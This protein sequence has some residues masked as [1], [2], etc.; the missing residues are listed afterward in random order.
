[1]TG[2]LLII[3]LLI[4]GG[5]LATLGDRLG[6]LIGK[7]RLSIFKLRP[8]RTAVFITVLTGS[9]ISAISLGFMLLVS[10]QLR[11]GLFELDDIQNK[12]QESRLALVPLKEE[13]NLL[14]KRITKGERE[15]KQLQR[16]IFSLRRGNVVIS[17]GQSLAIKTFKLDD[18]SNL[19]QEIDGLLNQANIYSYLRARPG[20]KPNKRILYVRKDNIDLI[21][22]TLRS[23]GE[24]VVNIRS[25]NNVLKGDYY[26]IALADILP[27]KNIVKDGEVLAEI[28]IDLANNT[29]DKIVNSKIQILL[30]EAFNEVKRRGSI[31]SELQMYDPGQINNL[32][33]NLNKDQFNNLTIYAISKSNSDTADQISVGISI[34]KVSR[35]FK[36]YD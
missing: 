21:E 36:S 15:L 22:K 29:S 31:I 17:S 4:L 7:A 32:A 14:E 5:L 30:S 20:E 27:N 1:V 16:D 25:V 8:K 19:K 33:R 3:S 12:L 10:R 35:K 23:E 13:R 34:G 6:S 26:I 24:W 18:S 9:L 2:W 11:I 28:Y